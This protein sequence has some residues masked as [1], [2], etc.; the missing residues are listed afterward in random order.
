MLFANNS[1]FYFR[2]LE[3]IQDLK[4]AFALRYKVW[5]ELGYI[6]NEMQSEINLLEIDNCDRYAIP[7]GLFNSEK[8]LVGTIRVVTEGEQSRWSAKIESFVNNLGDD[9]LINNYHKPYSTPFAILESFEGMVPVW[10]E[11]SLNFVSFGELSRV[12]I[13]KEFQGIGLSSP[14]IDFALAIALNEGIKVVFLACVEKQISL[15]ARHGFEFIDDVK[16]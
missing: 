4:E 10:K 11:L 1:P 3:T 14:L 5:S 7:I 9:I 13:S 15:Y 2:L 16:T 6:P 8:K 12:I